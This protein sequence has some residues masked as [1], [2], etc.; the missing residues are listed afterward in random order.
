MMVQPEVVNKIRL[1]QSSGFD[2]RWQNYP[3]ASVPHKKH[4]HDKSLFTFKGH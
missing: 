1:P 2:Y 4:S 3:L